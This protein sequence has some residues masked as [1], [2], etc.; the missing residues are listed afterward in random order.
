MP[1]SQSDS[2]PTP[3]VPLV[4]HV[5]QRRN[6]VLLVALLAIVAT[7]IGA[8]VFGPARGARDDI[9][10]VRTDLHGT[11]TTLQATLRTTRA[12]L[13]RTTALLHSTETA[14]TVSRQGLTVARQSEQLAGTT[15]ANTTMLV[16]QTGSTLTTVQQV[17]TALGPL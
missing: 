4:H 12:S 3:A 15:T 5:A 9:G 2:P 10:H 14:L 7:A 1:T 17:V 11:H 13:A 6:V 16:Q 8:L